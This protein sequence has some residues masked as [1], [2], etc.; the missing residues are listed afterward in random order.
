MNKECKTYLRCVKRRLIALPS[1][2]KRLLDGLTEE[3]EE[4][5]DV[6]YDEIVMR[7][8][9]PESVAAELQ[10]SVGED[11][12]FSAKRRTRIGVILL[13]VILAI[14]LALFAYYI[15]QIEN[16]AYYLT[17]ENPVVE[18]EF[19]NSLSWRY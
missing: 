19:V 3:L 9:R 6:R 10:S 4:L 8:G 17:P 15:I 16:E 13:A 18:T 1:T 11:E 2:K 7:L 14:V 5:G 12:V